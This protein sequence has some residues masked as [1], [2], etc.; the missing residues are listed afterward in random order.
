MRHASKRIVL[1]FLLTLACTPALQAA[2]PGALAAS[3]ARP[4][5]RHLFGRS[6]LPAAQSETPGYRAYSYLLLAPS[7]NPA[8]RSAN[9]SILSAYLAL[10][11]I[12]RVQAAGAEPQ[13]LDIVYLPLLAAP[14]SNPS[15]AWL[16]AHFDSD[17]AR[18][19][20]SA[21]GA[22]GRQSPTLVSYT[23]PLP[24]KSAVDQNELLVQDLSAGSATLVS[25]LE[26]QLS[27]S[28]TPA[29]P[30]RGDHRITGREFLR[31][32]TP[33]GSGYGLYSYVLFGEPPNAGNRILYRA[34]LD[35][36]LAIVEVREFEAEKQPR[37]N[38]N[39]TY[40]PLRE[41][42]SAG[43]TTDWFLDHYDFARAQIILAKLMD[44]PVGPYIVSC[45]SPL[46]AATSIDSGRLL[47]EDLS[48]VTPD[49]AFL[50]VN[51]FKA[52]AGRPQYWD[53]PALRTLMLNL[54]NQIAVAAQAFEEARTADSNLH[55]SLA[56]RI[57]IPQ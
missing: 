55:T 18:S 41:L 48:G 42:P 50:W 39:V 27:P 26:K 14:P 3:S 10:D 16:L 38:L 31:P 29:A 37:A 53:K 8:N 1:F 30:V 4:P 2:A 57:N 36:F 9:E 23:A 6:F 28:P 40:L 13:D 54:R 20:L 15:A 45:N 34:V 17:R 22:T 43:A 12:G 7:A 46:S 11:E 44:R 35:A 32:D 49:L 51:E 24:G 21:V 25:S 5:D 52:Q 33:E 19:I 47:I 56:S